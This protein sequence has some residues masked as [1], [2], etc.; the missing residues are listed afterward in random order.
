VLV[1]QQHHAVDFS[2]AIQGVNCSLCV[3][4]A[5]VLAETLLKHISNTILLHNA[6]LDISEFAH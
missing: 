1:H 6:G 3:I 5:N 2:F 4:V